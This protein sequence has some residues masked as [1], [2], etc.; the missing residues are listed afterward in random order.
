[1]NKKHWHIKDGITADVREILKDYGDLEA[2]L[3]FNRHIETREAARNFLHASFSDDSHDPYL[4]DGMKEAVAEIIFAVRGQELIVIYGDY[5][6]DGVTSSAVLY[7]T[8][9]TLK[10]KVEVY[11]PDRVTEGYGLNKEAVKDISQMGAKLI[12]TVDNGIRNQEEVDYALSLGLKV[13]ITDHHLPPEPS[14]L[15]RTIMVNPWLCVGRY[16]FS[17]LAG[18]GVAA[19]VAGAIIKETKLEDDLKQRLEE[20]IL[21][22]V[23]VGTVADCVPL[24]GEN[25][26]LVKKGLEI[27]NKRKRLGLNELCEVSKLD[28]EKRLDAWNIGFQLAP[29]LNAA[30]RL[31]HANTAFELLISTDQSEARELASSLNQNNGIRQ[32]ITEELVQKII[33]TETALE[34]HAIIIAVSPEEETWNEGII[35]LAAGRVTERFYRPTLVITGENGHYKGSGRS[36]KEIDLIETMGEAKEFIKKYGGHK[37]ACGFSIE[38]KENLVK[39]KARLNEVVEVKLAGLELKP[40]LEI[41]LEWPLAKCDEEMLHT[42]DAFSPFGEGNPRP[43]FTV[44]GVRVVDK[45]LMGQESQHLKLKLE[46]NGA[47]KT[48][49][50][51]SVPAGWLEIKIGDIIDLVYFPDMNE[52]NGRREVQLK[53]QDLKIH[54]NS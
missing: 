31:Q 14:A 4:L 39:F 29:R 2:S 54:E 41:D 40:S 25:R 8:L 37:M 53:I 24:L 28:K 30:G 1:M 33:K 38:G 6:A 51:F 50:A 20:R 17:S 5:D 7:E 10:A 52:F 18:V 32:Q 47:L 15:P 23:A 44:N 12:V 26:I 49:I 3:F 43:V 22:L 21:D 35:G 19:K 9:R 11:L 42:I 27:L 36:I 48:A 34:S 45:Q 13:I 46:S 16:P